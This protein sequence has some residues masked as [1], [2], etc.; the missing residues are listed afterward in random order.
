M[1]NELDV[2][3]LADRYIAQWNEPDPAARSTL[4]RELWAQD[5]IQVL[6]DPPEEIR[7]AATSLAFAA[8]PLEVRGHDAVDARVTRA[9]EMFVA[10]GEHVFEAD[11]ETVVLLPNVIG[12]RW[13]MVSSRNGKAVGGGLDILA[14]DQDGKISTDHQF[15]GAN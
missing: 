12:V 2:K 7:Q 6:L 15:I 10:P 14:L 1:S 5:G 8:P 3:R 11:G 4:I 9:Y 13:S